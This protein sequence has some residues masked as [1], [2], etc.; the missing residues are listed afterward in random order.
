LLE[1]ADA[2]V[3]ISTRL[4]GIGLQGG[5]AISILFRLTEDV[6]HLSL[7]RIEALV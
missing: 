6:R 4:G 3:L 1:G 5:K 2:R 7:E